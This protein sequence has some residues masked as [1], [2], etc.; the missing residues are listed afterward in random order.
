MMDVDVQLACEGGPI[1]DA[2]T[3]A[4]WVRAALA[5]R[6]ERGELTVRVVGEAEAAELNARYRGR[7]GP[8]NV[9]SFP[10]EAPPGSEALLLLGDI[11]ACAPVLER[12]A[13]DQG[14]ELQAHW[15]HVVV[16]GALHLAGLD[17]VR[18]EEA[19]RMERAEREILAGLGYPDPYQE[20]A[21]G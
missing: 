6:L 19:E 9:L 2:A 3:I 10:F 18:P 20:V 17:H 15:A 14:K 16:H 5:G 8:T 11:V 4:A 7:S 1:P 12:E 13:R 21:G